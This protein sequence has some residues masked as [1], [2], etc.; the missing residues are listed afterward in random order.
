MF[1]LPFIYLFPILWGINGIFA[2]QP[3]SD[4]LALLLSA[5]LI[6]REHRLLLSPQYRPCSEP[7]AGTV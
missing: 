4:L 1:L 2:A 3:V 6:V 7:E 5:I